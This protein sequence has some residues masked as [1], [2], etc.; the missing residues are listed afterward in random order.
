[1]EL[2]KIRHAVVQ[3]GSDFSFELAFLMHRCLLT[4][5]KISW[6]V[7]TILSTQWRCAGQRGVLLTTKLY[8][9]RVS[10]PHKKI[11]NA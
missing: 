5:V 9:S 10:T 8:A 4:N 1:M 7:R 11:R 6:R 3:T 2:K